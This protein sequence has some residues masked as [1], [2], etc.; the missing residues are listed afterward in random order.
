M[1]LLSPGRRA[2]ETSNLFTSLFVPPRR[3]FNRRGR[4]ASERASRPGREERRRT[5]HEVWLLGVPWLYRVYRKR[6]TAGNHELECNR[7]YQLHPESANNRN[8]AVQRKGRVR[9]GSC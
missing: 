5:L 6:R 2:H 7:L 4:V 9:R 3:P 1:S 8:A